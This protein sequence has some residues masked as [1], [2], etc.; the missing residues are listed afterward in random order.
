MI[1]YF[2]IVHVMDTGTFMQICTLVVCGQVQKA[3]QIVGTSQALRCLSVVLETLLS[4]AVLKQEALSL[5]L[6]TYF[7]LVKIT[8]RISSS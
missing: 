2:S 7:L 8:V 6:G 5:Q 4:S 1:V 3:Q